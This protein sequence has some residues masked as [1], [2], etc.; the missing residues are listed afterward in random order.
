M[1]TFTD[2]LGRSVEAPSPPARI[3]SL[4]PS[5][6]ETL[7]SFG[8]GHSVVGVTRFCAEPAD[9][10]SRLPKVGGTKDVDVGAVL[11]LAPDLV[12]ANAEENRRE[13]IEG[14]IEAG[15]T[16]MVTFP[17]TVADALEELQVLAEIVGAGETAAAILDDASREV[18]GDST[19]P[20]EAVPVFCP[21]WRR[22]WM[23]I[24]PH[25]YIHDMI[26]LC[27]GRNI[28]ADA[29]PRYPQVSLAEVRARAPEVV[30]LPDEP[31]PFEDKHAEEVI[32]AL[33]PVRIHLVDGKDLCWY[34]PRIGPAVRAFRRLLVEAN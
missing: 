30:L 21:I 15:A 12:L 18:A 20:S 29:N 26:R 23:T 28:F 34:G 4:V 8:V 11:G 27:G 13:D 24:G 2:A 17:R 19:P 1:I 22:P 3:V 9:G 32:E 33:G 14:L 25:T 31:Y 10:V 7:F 6:T 5:V 16:V